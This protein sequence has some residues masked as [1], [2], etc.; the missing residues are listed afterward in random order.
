V[1]A[2]DVDALTNALFDV[3]SAPDTWRA[4]ARHAAS[5][6]QTRFGNASVT[7]R[8]VDVYAKAIA[9]VVDSRTFIP[10]PTRVLGIIPA[11]NEAATLAA[12]VSDVRT[13]CPD[14]DLLVVDDG[15]SDGTSDLLPRLGVRWLELPERMGVG[16]AMRAGLRYARRMGYDSV[17]RLD[18]DGQHRAQD[19]ALTLEPLQAGR[20]DVVL[21]SRF[22]ASAN[23]P[24]P[25]GR[26]AHRLL[27][28]CLSWLTRRSVTDPTSGFCALGPRAVRLL[29]EHHP[30]GY[31]EAE[32]RLFLSRNKLVSI[33]VAVESRAR[34]GGRTSLTPGRIIGASARVLLAMIIVPLRRGAAAA[35]HE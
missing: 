18:G 15:S 13:E 16:C 17:V 26:I 8:L 29:A 33:E 9:P 35:D 28:R 19:I 3:L 6:V 4:A 32:L 34:M 22:L 30:T 10:R 27:G 21:G 14:L 20:A 11:H 12:V 24:R 23:R 7:E 25:D 5:V 2:G 1:T 31:P